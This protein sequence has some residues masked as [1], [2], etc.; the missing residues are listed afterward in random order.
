MAQRARGPGPTHRLASTTSGPA[1]ASRASSN[2]SAART[3]SKIPSTAAPPASRVNTGV[4]ASRAASR[5]PE[6]QRT[7]TT[8]A[9]VR[10]DPPDAESLPDPT[11]LRVGESA[12]SATEL[13]APLSVQRASSNEIHV[14]LPEH[15]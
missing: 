2:E 13:T 10:V 8:S 14:D 11:P 4:P 5:A 6:A 15:V 7:P 3:Q 1:P 12:T 9:A